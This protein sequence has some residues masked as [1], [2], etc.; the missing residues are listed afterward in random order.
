MSYLLHLRLLAG[1]NTENS[2]NWIF[3]QFRREYKWF[4]CFIVHISCDCQKLNGRPIPGNMF[5][6]T[7]P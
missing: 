2:C 3:L 5:R 6:Q 4:F 1:E 7:I